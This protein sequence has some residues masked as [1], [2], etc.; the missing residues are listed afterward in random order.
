MAT[1]QQIDA[2]WEQMI[3][4]ISKAYGNGK[5][6]EAHVLRDYAP[7]QSWHDAL[8]DLLSREA[9]NEKRHRRG[10]PPLAVPGFSVNSGAKLI[11]LGNF[12]D[13]SKRT[14]IPSALTFIQWRKT[15]AEMHLIGYL[16]RAVVSQEFRDS[17]KSLDYAQLMKAA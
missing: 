8:A 6:E 2:L 15:A 17:V 4:F 5:D 11:L 13:G 12:A 14:E 1:K 16:C 10:H 9:D 7:N 3:E